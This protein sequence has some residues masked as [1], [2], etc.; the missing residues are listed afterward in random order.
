[1]EP[2]PW[3]PL[4]GAWRTAPDQRVTVTGA[5]AEELDGRQVAPPDLCRDRQGEREPSWR[6]PGL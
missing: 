1:M 5:G 4:E 6:R 2:D 3:E